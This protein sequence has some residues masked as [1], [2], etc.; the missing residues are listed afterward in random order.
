MTEVIPG[1]HWL[2]LPITLAESTLA[3]VNAYLVQGDG[4]FFLV[5]VGWNTEESFNSLQKQLSEIGADIKDISRILITHVH[6]DH[7]GLA[8]ELKQLSPAKISLHYM[9]KDL[10]E[11]RYVN[12]DKLLQQME[13]WLHVNGVPASELHRL[14]MASVGMVRFVSPAAPDIALKGGETISAGSFSFQVLWT[15][16]HSP[17]HICLYEPTQKILIS[18]DHILPAITPNIGLNP[19]SSKNPLGDYLNC[20]NEMKQLKVNL[21]LPGHGAPFTGFQQRIDEITQNHNQRSSEILEA[22]KVRAKTAYQIAGEITW[23][24]NMKPVSQQDLGA[25]EKSLTLVKTLAHLESLRF[26]GKVDK[27]LKDNVVYYQAT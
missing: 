16:G 20:L 19:Q 25:W 13:Q 10:I 4:D 6:P 11:S 17:G 5:D 2:K 18:G 8:G 1:I 21:I 7:Y 23:I 27:F 12:M 15:P 14:Q 3:H 24:V 26:A 9:E 22:A